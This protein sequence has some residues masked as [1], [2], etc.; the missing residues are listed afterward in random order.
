MG[1]GEGRGEEGEG[2]R[3]GKTSERVR[4]TRSVNGMEKG[5]NARGGSVDKRWPLAVET[6][7]KWRK[8]RCRWGSRTPASRS[9]R[10]AEG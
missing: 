3:W 5:N 1:R 6:F 8:R 10:S 7:W 9:M 2:V 4:T